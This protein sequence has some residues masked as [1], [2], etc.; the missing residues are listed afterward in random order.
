MFGIEQDI[1]PL[2][3]GIRYVFARPWWKFWHPQLT[4]DEIRRDIQAA[5]MGEGE[6]MQRYGILVNP[7]LERAIA[8]E[9]G[10]DPDK[11]MTQALKMEARLALMQH[12]MMVFSP[13]WD[14]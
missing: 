2:V 5:L 14:T 9:W 4:R 8:E 11:P 7:A 6:R 10:H 13:V 12:Q 3:R 1:E